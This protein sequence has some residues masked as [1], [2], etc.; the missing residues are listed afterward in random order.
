[1]YMRYALVLIGIGTIAACSGTAETGAGGQ[2]GGSSSSS[3]SSA[4]NSSSGMGGQGG[5]GGMGFPYCGGKQ[6]YPCAA[7]E[8]CDFDES[9]AY[10][11]AGDNTGQCQPRPTVCTKDCPGVCGCDGQFYCNACVAQA[12]GTDVSDQSGCAPSACVQAAKGI[13]VQVDK[14]FCTAVVRLDYTSKAPLGF[15]I[16]CGGVPAGG[17]TEAKARQTAQMDTGYG[18][19]GSFISG[20]TPQDHYIFVEQPSDFGG[21]AAVSAKSGLSVFGGGIVWA[22][23]GQITYPKTWQAVADLGVGCGPQASNPPPARGFDLPSGAA[24]SAMDIDA[25]VAVAWDSALA[26][27]F[28]NAG[29]LVHDAVV[30][31]YPRS[32]GVF[33]PTTAEWIVLFNSGLLE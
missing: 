22:G 17:V 24:L 28:G 4:S 15:Q 10:C 20:P 26:D 11:G 7:D 8:W 30:L 13:T 9:F 27:G 1:M 5:Q 25:A 14:T 29:H 12:A 18:L 31:K 33:D 2:G 16:V 3:S 21:V 23:T 32:V 19:N 6:G